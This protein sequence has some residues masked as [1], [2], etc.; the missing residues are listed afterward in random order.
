MSIKHTFVLLVSLTFI[1]SALADDMQSDP[2]PCK[3]LAKPCVEAGYKGKD[4]WTQCMKPL[5]LGQPVKNIKVDPAAVKACRAD[6]IKQMEQDLSD[7][8]A[9]DK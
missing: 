4:F 2:K 9:A 5:V 1:Q 7:M 3:A 8:K 6:K